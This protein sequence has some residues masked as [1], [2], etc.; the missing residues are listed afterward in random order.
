M[1]HFIA[2]LLEGSPGRVFAPQTG[3]LDV[4]HSAVLR[5]LFKLLAD[6]LRVLAL[7]VLLAVLQ[8]VSMYGMHALYI[9]TCI[10]IYM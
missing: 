4:I 1:R 9:N 3:R 2:M 7:R 8:W 10:I 5:L 6:A